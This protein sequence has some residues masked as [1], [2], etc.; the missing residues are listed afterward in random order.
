MKDG[1]CD[2]RDSGSA[3]L[4][5][6][7]APAD[8]DIVSGIVVLLP[9]ALA[10]LLVNTGTVHAFA[11]G[12]GFDLMMG[13]GT[14]AVATV[15]AVEGEY[16]RGYAEEVEDGTEAEEEDRVDLADAGLDVRIAEDGRLQAGLEGC[17]GEAGTVA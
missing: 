6:N 1:V 17:N 9:L 12:G 13:E 11:P 8:A 14:A 15:A 10:L 16:V 2:D 5:S 3:W 4:G 7:P